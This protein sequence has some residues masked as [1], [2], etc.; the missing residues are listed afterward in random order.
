MLMCCKP[1]RVAG[2]SL[3]ELM[4]TVA[5]AATLAAIVIPT[6]QS[7]IRKSRRT[8]A[9]TAVM[10]LANREERY[11]SVNNDYSDSA[12]QLGYAKPGAADAQISNLSVGAGYYT[13]TVI[14]QGVNPPTPATFS[15]TATAVGTQAKDTACQTFTVD[16]KGTQTSTPAADCW[17]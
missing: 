10:D 4:V 7:Q 16:D 3:I 5:V 12:V 1:R 8:E 13:V 2:F 11:Y 14:H 17:N 9:R 6:Y 15:I